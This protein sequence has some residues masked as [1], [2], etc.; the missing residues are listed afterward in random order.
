M[1]SEISKSSRHS[2]IIGNFG[3]QVICNWLSRSGFEVAVVDHT[4]IDI[5]AYNAASEQRI[6]ITVKSRTRSIGTE[7][8]TVNIFLNQ[9][10][11]NDSD[12][13]KKACQSFACEPWIGIYVEAT[14]YANV[15]LLS[16][17]HYIKNYQGRE[18]KKIGDW[19]MTAKY[20]E[21]Y[22]NDTQVQKIEMRFQTTNWHW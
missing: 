4:G 12:K 5:V 15:Y 13:V 1:S 21:Q 11:K 17:E 10:G 2:K 20:R 9:N 14:D 22:K 3:E 16:L 18:G 6:G 19:K 7:E 8:D